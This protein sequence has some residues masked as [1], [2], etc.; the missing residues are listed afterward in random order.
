MDR[1]QIADDEIAGDFGNDDTSL[2]VFRHELFLL[3]HSRRLIL[4]NFCTQVRRVDH[5]VRP[6]RIGAVDG[7]SIEHVWRACLQLRF[8]DPF[9]DIDGWHRNSR[10]CW[11][12]NSFLVSLTEFAAAYFFVVEIFQPKRTAVLILPAHRLLHFMRAEQVPFAASLD[13]FHVE[14]R[15]ADAMEYIMRAHPLVAV[16]QLQVEE[17]E[18]I[19]VEHVQIYRNR[20]FA[21]SKLINANGCVVQLANPRNNAGAGV[22]VAA[23]VRAAGANLA[24]IYADAAAH[25]AKAGYIRIGIEN[26]FQRVVHR[27]DEAAGQLSSDFFTSIGHRWRSSRHVNIAHRPVGF[28]YIIQTLVRRL[29]VH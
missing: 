29:L 5:A 24:E 28:F 15:E 17:S 2:P 6:V 8:H 11:M 21:G 10:Q 16:V 3:Y 7:I 22:F 13:G 27:I 4:H 14:V 19:L 25:F 20:S 12:V 9:H 18:N 1:I 26:A 23:D